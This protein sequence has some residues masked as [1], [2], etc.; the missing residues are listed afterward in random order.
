M[1][2][3]ACRVSNPI[4]KPVHLRAL[5]INIYN[6]CTI[7]DVLGLGRGSVWGQIHTSQIMDPPRVNGVVSQSSDKWTLHRKYLFWLVYDILLFC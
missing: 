2:N 7:R 6:H 4:I 3:S 5:L 1:Q